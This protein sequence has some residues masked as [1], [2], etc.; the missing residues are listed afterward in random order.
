MELP[1]SPVAS[2]K[3][4]QRGLLGT[5][6]PALWGGWTPGSG[7]AIL[8][9]TGLQMCLR[10]QAPHSHR[11]MRLL[12]LPDI[13]NLMKDRT[14][15][16]AAC[17]EGA[18][19]PQHPRPMDSGVDPAGWC[20]QQGLGPDAA[21]LVVVR[22][23]APMPNPLGWAGLGHGYQSPWAGG[24]SSALAVLRYLPAQVAARVRRGRGLRGHIRLPDVPTVFRLRRAQGWADS[25]SWNVRTAPE[26]VCTLEPRGTGSGAPRPVPPTLRPHR[27][28]L[29][30]RQGTLPFP[31]AGRKYSQGLSNAEN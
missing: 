13:S 19:E 11:F 28:P 25:Y 6:V 16:G 21:P 29:P 31:T 20:G 27:M 12:R 1:L 26:G 5:G 9:L 7:G 4:P 3:G 14:G 30:L 8:I 15:R 2:G 17:Q 23:L 24:R 22:D 18:S 10:G